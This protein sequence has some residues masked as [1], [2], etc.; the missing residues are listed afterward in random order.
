MLDKIH[1]FSLKH[2]VNP[3]KADC[4]HNAIYEN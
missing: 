4:L 1:M 2:H 3:V